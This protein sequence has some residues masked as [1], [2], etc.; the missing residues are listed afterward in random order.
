MSNKYDQRTTT[1]DPN[2]RL[3]QV[4]YAIQH[5][6]QDGSVVGILAKDG[7]V[8]AAEKK[9]TSKLF[10][11]TRESGKLYKIDDHI[12]AAVSGV[13]ADANYLIDYSRVHCQRH[14]YSHCEPIYVEELVKFLCNEKHQY[15]QF[16]SSRPFGVGLMYAGYDKMRGF[17]LY[18]SDPSGN[19]AS[20][21]AHATG[22]GCVNAIS[23]LK[24]D[25]KSE[26]NLKE[27]LILAAQVL[28]KSMDAATPTADK[29][30]IGVMQKDEE[31]K[32]VQRRVEGAELQKILEEAK[33]FELNEGK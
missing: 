5:I 30:E 3:L 21:N 15:T 1:F 25:Y 7:V 16:G 8:I 2:G 27:A 23:T 32:M 28:G 33:V 26:C 6:N 31:G 10:V 29:F 12:L 4:E 13:V 9:E 24:D 22:R 20:W 14:L 19:Y 17:Q 18:H 11:P